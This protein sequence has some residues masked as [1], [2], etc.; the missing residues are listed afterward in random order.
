[1]IADY[2]EDQN[3]Q[4]VLSQLRREVEETVELG[5]QQ[6]GRVYVQHGR[7]WNLSDNEYFIALDKLKT[8]GV[9]RRTNASYGE[10][11]VRMERVDTLVDAEEVVP[12]TQRSL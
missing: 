10:V 1:V 5:S 7:P 4:L 12:D 2:P 11:L 8:L 9:W 3:I 6:W